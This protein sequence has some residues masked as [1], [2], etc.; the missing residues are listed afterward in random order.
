MKEEIDDYGERHWGADFDRNELDKLME[1]T[2][3]IDIAEPF[4]L[5]TKVACATKNS[6]F[7]KDFIIIE[8]NRTSKCFEVY[9]KMLDFDNDRLVNYLSN[10]KSVITNL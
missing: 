2:D 10:I 3:K 1:N 9:K 4:I 8:E 7:F 6:S 5:Q